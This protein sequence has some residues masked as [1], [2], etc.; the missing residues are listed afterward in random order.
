MDVRRAAHVSGSVQSLIWFI[1]DSG[2]PLKRRFMERL[3]DVL[4][5]DVPAV[6]GS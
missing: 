2:V 6:Y 3:W 5:M 1:W 4:V